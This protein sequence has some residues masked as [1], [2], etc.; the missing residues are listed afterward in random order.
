MTQRE[1]VVTL[2]FGALTV[3]ALVKASRTDRFRMQIT[4]IDDVPTKIEVFPIMPGKT[5]GTVAPLK[6]LTHIDM[7]EPRP[8]PEG[9]LVHE[10]A[11]TIWEA[12]E[13]SHLADPMPT[14]LKYTARGNSDAECMVRDMARRIIAQIE[15]NRAPAE[16]PG[17]T[18]DEWLKEGT[19]TTRGER[20]EHFMGMPDDFTARQM[21][22]SWLIGAWNAGIESGQPLPRDPDTGF[23]LDGKPFYPY[24]KR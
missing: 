12:I 3:G 4:L 15:Q 5:S 8:E 22:V 7:R 24:D 19:V 13:W 16:P 14:G 21:M 23:R 1:R 11:R 17:M 9:Y 20:L 18:F 10:T 6:M 2:Y